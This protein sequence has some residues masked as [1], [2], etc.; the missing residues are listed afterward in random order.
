MF[1]NLWEDF[2]IGQFRVV[3][4]IKEDLLTIEAI[5]AGSRGDVYK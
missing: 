1:K 2:M 3:F 4:A 5:K